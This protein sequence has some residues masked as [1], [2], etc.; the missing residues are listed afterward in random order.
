MVD[1]LCGGIQ[2]G[3]DGNMVANLPFPAQVQ[4]DKARSE[5]GDLAP[6][7]GGDVVP[8]GPLHFN[9][10]QE[11]VNN[12]E[13]SPAH[14]LEN[15]WQGPIPPAVFGLGSEIDWAAEAPSESGDLDM[16]QF[17]KD[18]LDFTPPR[19]TPADPLLRVRKPVKTCRGEGPQALAMH[20]ARKARKGPAAGSQ[21]RQASQAVRDSQVRRATMG[22]VLQ[23][24]DLEPTCD[25]VTEPSPQGHS[26]HFPQGSFS[27]KGVPSGPVPT[28]LVSII[29]LLR[30]LIGTMSLGAQGPAIMALLDSLAELVAAGQTAS[31][32]APL[33][34][35]VSRAAAAPQVPQVP[36]VSADGFTTVTRRRRGRKARNAA[37]LRP[38]PP[39]PSQ[40]PQATRQPQPAT[41]Q[42]QQQQQQPRR[43]PPAPRRQPPRP[44]PQQQRPPAPRRQQAPTIGNRRNPHVAAAKKAA[45]GGEKPV[46]IIRPS[47]PNPP[48]PLSKEE[49]SKLRVSALQALPDHVTITG[50][51]PVGRSSLGMSVKERGHLPAVLANLGSKL[52]GYEVAP[53]QSRS[54]R[55]ILF[56]PA[57]SKDVS[58]AALERQLKEENEGLIGQGAT[59]PA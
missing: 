49:F 21:V 6:R 56:S 40:V 51:F 5:S 48:A 25:L 53:K 42:Q 23:D 50:T 12:G 3:A 47:G 44:G 1:R 59:G 39:R 19:P 13:R 16:E 36:Q 34:G 46:V 38:G 55:V 32:P 7:N 41:Q 22:Q 18:L 11:P 14:S 43:Q 45:A 27:P 33:S 10:D 26:E 24:M 37:P 2:P 30:T 4:Q 8:P 54:P 28:A 52:Q 9:L 29:A 15:C 57:L 58:A 31:P 20:D 35:S 17:E